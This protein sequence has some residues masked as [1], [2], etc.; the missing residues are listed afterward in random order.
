VAAV[1]V[2]GWA[3]V[4]Y[5]LVALRAYRVLGLNVPGEKAHDPAVA[6]D[7]RAAYEWLNL[8]APP[9]AVT[10]H[11]PDVSRA[12]AYGLYGRHRVAVAD[13]HNSL[14]L[15]ANHRAVD[16]RLTDL[17]PVFTDA[18]PAADVRRRLQA[19]KVDIALVAADDPVWREPASWVWQTEPLRAWPHVRLVTIPGAAP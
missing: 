9:G 15:G 10:Q 14:L 6:H 13:R 17:I 5:D 8:H 18:L 7:L 19:H 3:G 1:L 12:F 4:A 11:N 16:A 2:L